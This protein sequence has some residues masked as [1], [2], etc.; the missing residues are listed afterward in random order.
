MR[1]GVQE[2]ETSLIKLS[3]SSI[4]AL[5]TRELFAQS[6]SSKSSILRIIREALNGLPSCLVGK[7][8]FGDRRRIIFR[9]SENLSL[10]LL[11]SLLI[12]RKKKE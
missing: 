1:Q 7:N 9:Q 10:R 8:K 3:C 2:E 6:Y 11:S 4:P 12:V 5:G